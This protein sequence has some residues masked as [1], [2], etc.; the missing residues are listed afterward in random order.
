MNK[1][2]LL[3]I[4]TALA[5]VIIP[6]HSFAS[7]IA[8][9]SKFGVG[10]RTIG[11]GRAFVG[12]A[13]DANSI[14][15]NP[16]GGGW[17]SYGSLV[18]TTTRL[19]DETNVMSFGGILPTKLG[20]VGFAY[21]DANIAGSTVTYRDPISGKVTADPTRE[22]MSFDDNVTIISLSSSPFISPFSPDVKATLGLNCK[23]FRQ[24]ITGG[25]VGIANASG[26]DMDLGFLIKPADWMRIGLSALNVLPDSYTQLG[27][28]TK[29]D[30][31]ENRGEGSENVMKA[32][33]GLKLPSSM[34]PKGMG[35][36][37]L[38]DADVDFY[39][40]K[41]RPA[42][43]HIGTEWWPSDYIGLRMGFDQDIASGGGTD[44]IAVI[45]N[46][47]YGAGLKY[48]NFLFDYAFK[49]SSLADA[50]SHYFSMSYLIPGLF[51]KPL[52]TTISP[53]DRTVT[54]ESFVMLKAK[55]PAKVKKVFVGET[56]VDIITSG[57]G[58]FE[59][60][61]DLIAGKNPI[62]MRGF[63]GNNISIATGEC[64]ILRLISF[65]DVP[66]T[67]WAIEP[68]SYLG[69]LGIVSGFPDGTFR[70][71]DGL[72]RAEMVTLLVRAKNSLLPE[73]GFEMFSDVGSG[74]WASQYIKVSV[75][76]NYAKG[77]PDGTFKPAGKLTRAEAVAIIVRFAGL[78]DKD[79]VTTAP[80]SDV[81]LN[82]WAVNTINAAKQAGILSYLGSY[83]FEPSREITRAEACEMLSKIKLMSNKINDLLN[84]NIGY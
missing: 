51:E 82:H 20:S 47:T 80:F 40:A 23:F 4:L 15:F 30:T 70:P 56:Q 58:Y 9:P 26:F 25:T 67:Y 36:E 32:G 74:H 49:P 11:M 45:T 77:Y 6:V 16:A 60:A 72:T 14:F 3:I 27:G 31:G 28:I 64:R 84:F 79:A 33:L 83:P 81:E 50:N 54:Y 78:S 63:D 75:D 73:A 48:S 35:K 8:D 19:M 43:F 69:T 5:F 52:I 1:R 38:I 71:D 76:E 53:A 17:A 59:S 22:G 55:A 34:L 13:D 44:K 2:L 7:L 21:I 24:K 10:A 66:E 65:I 62:K 57:G 46:L 18:S 42:L 39:L 41:A 68:V 29:W 61:V 37:L 12:I